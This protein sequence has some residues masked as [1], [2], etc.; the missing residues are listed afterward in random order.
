METTYR[1]DPH[2]EYHR[3]IIIRVTEQD[4]LFL[5]RRETATGTIWGEVSRDR[6]EAIATAFAAFLVS[7]GID[8]C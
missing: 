7:R 1:F 2:P 4:G 5:G 6:D 3:A 8:P